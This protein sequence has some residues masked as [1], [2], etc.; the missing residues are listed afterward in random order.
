MA[1]SKAPSTR[2]CDAHCSSFPPTSNILF[3]FARR[4]Y[5]ISSASLLSRSSSSFRLH[6][7]TTRC[8]RR[9]TSRPRYCTLRLS[10]FAAKNRFIK[11][12]KAA[13]QARS[14]PVRTPSN[15]S[16]SLPIPLLQTD[17]DEIRCI[18]IRTNTVATR[19]RTNPPPLSV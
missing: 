12:T 3:F 5:R 19:S 4:F 18:R 15:S 6:L 14:Y 9:F 17:Q 7:A 11:K 8:P 1:P 16:S 13:L 10:W 2:S